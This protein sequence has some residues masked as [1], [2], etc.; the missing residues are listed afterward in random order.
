MNHSQKTLVEK[1]VKYNLEF[2][3]KHLFVDNLPVQMSE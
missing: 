1:N 3:G 2:K